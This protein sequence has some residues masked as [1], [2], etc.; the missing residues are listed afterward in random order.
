[1][2]ALKLEGVTVSEINI[3]NTLEALQKEVE[4]YIECLTLVPE[5]AVMIVNEEGLLRELPH[6]A[7]ATIIAARKIVGTALVVGVDGEE[8]CDVPK[9]VERAIKIRFA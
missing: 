5:Q 4:G 1:M 9:N 6:N 8:F 2:K 3:D 7:L